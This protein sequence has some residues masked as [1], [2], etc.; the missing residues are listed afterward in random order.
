MFDSVCQASTG[1]DGWLEL[2]TLR[3]A[4]IEAY[5]QYCC[6]IRGSFHL[7]G[8]WRAWIEVVGVV[9]ECKSDAYLLM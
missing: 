5:R 6:G 1:R 8:E 7:A 2:L 9:D 4:H 3:G